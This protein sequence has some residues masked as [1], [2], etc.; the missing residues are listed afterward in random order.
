MW[1]CESCRLTRISVPEIFDSITG[2]G[3]IM[4]ND[5]E[6]KRLAS[7]FVMKCYQEGIDVTTI[8]HAGGWIIQ[9]IAHLEAARRARE[10]RTNS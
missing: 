1:N 2:G 9:V 5:E 7:E 6:A 8:A 10:V 4:E 3:H